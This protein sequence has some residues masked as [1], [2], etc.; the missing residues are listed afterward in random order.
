M[1][2]ISN[3]LE[4][5]L[6][7]LTKQPIQN[8]IQ[9]IQM[10]K[11]TGT[12]YIEE[13]E[14]T[15]EPEQDTS[16]TTLAD[17]MT[18]YNQ[19]KEAGSRD[20]AEITGGIKIASV[21]DIKEIAKE[22]TLKIQDLLDSDVEQTAVGRAVGKGLAV[23]D[24]KSSFLTK[25]FGSKKKALKEKDIEGMTIDALVKSLD[26]AVNAKRD[27]AIATTTKLQTIKENMIE[28]LAIFEQ[29]EQQVEQLLAKAKPATKEKFDAQRL[30]ISVK[31]TIENIKND[32]QTVY[33]PLVMMAVVAV[34]NIQNNLP[35]VADDLQR[36]LAAKAG[37]KN[38]KQLNDIYTAYS[39]MGKEARNKIKLA[40]N[41]TMLDTISLV[42]NTGIDVAQIE[43][44]TKADLEQQ[45]KIQQKMAETV[46]KI[47]QDYKEMARI[48]DTLI[49]GRKHVNSTMI[50]QYSMTEPR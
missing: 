23:I 16:T 4:A 46:N 40:V 38:I 32:I 3:A 5:D 20:A 14:I 50:S 47:E 2:W 27:E 17:L 26:V 30:A 41:Q 39:E 7:K 37:Q 42:G 34:E 15:I 18:T 19:A 33:E 10:S 22:Y 29:I 35:T 24:T 13:I 12:S 1:A 31:G 48:Q 28:R 49:E 6:R 8:L 43:K 11:E 44:A 9:E 21:D 36:I 45:K 25:W